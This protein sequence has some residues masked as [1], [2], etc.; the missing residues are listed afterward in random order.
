MTPALATLYGITD[1]GTVAVDVGDVHDA[2]AGF[3]QVRNRGLG[4]KI[5]GLEVGIDDVVPLRLGC[6]A[7]RRGIE[8]RGVVD[9]HVQAIERLDG[10]E[11][12][13]FRRALA[14][15]EIAAHQH[16]RLG[17]I[18]LQL[19]L[20]RVRRALGGVVMHHELH[21]LGVQ[22]ARDGG[23]DAMRPARDQGDFAFEG[24]VHHKVALLRFARSSCHKVT[25]YFVR[26][27]ID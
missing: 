21:A 19:F 27:A 4:Q 6:L 14:V 16:D 22:Q 8:T 1:Q 2:A 12:Q 17:A 20:Q 24:V 18:P 23:T 5:G 3:A 13:I 10:L 7:H 25:S 11:H 26:P 15:A 9:Q